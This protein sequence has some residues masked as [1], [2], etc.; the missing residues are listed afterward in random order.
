MKD[1]IQVIQIV[2]SSVGNKDGLVCVYDLVYSNIDNFIS[3]LF[4]TT[5]TKSKGRREV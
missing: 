4:G 1:Q 2:A 5:S 3:N